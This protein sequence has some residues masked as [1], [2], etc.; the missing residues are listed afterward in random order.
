MTDQGTFLIAPSFRF[1]PH[2]GSIRLGSLLADPTRPHRVLTTIDASEL[3]G[4]YPDIEKVIEHGYEVL[5]SSR[6]TVSGA[7]W[8]RFLDTAGAKL[9]GQD[10]V[11]NRTQYSAEEVQTEYF[12]FDPSMDLIRARVAEPRV[13]AHMQRLMGPRKSVYMI[14]GVKIATKLSLVREASTLVSADLAADGAVP[15]PAGEVNLGMAADRSKLRSDREV[16]HL[17]QDVV[18]AYQLLKIEYAHWIGEVLKVD[19]HRSEA[20]FHGITEAT[21]PK[22]DNEELLRCSSAA[23][24]DLGQIGQGSQ[25][26][27]VVLDDATELKLITFPEKK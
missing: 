21:P 11:E 17:G 12:K 14:H 10:S 7:I 27:S 18:F 20:G 23:E 16:S 15:T 2:T 6:K 24:Q 9:G 19:E 3:P 4:T 13:K 26:L 25:V 22:D 5:R 1:I 8:A